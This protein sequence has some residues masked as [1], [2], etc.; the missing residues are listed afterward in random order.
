MTFVI[1]KLQAWLATLAA[2]ALAAALVTT[3]ISLYKER[4][5]HSKTRSELDRK[6]LAW[7]VERSKASKAL[8]DLTTKYREADRLLVENAAKA[9]KEK[10]EIQAKHTART[11]AL[12]ERLRFKPGGATPAP[13]VSCSTAGPA[14]GQ[15][16]GGRHLIVIPVE[17]GER[18]ISEAGRGDRVLEQLKYCEGRY[19]ELRLKLDAMR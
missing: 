9:S 19:E 6:S 5:D 12:L 15:T 2:I 7:E 4:R 8:A 10:N 13:D 11:N 18:I 16:P 1:S 3:G 17:S 14:F